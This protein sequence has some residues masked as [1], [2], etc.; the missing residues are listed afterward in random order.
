MPKKKLPHVATPPYDTDAFN[1]LAVLGLIAAFHAG[2]KKIFVRF[3]DAN[4]VRQSNPGKA[5]AK[6]GWRFF[7]Q[8]ENLVEV[9]VINL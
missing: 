7:L 1:A 2:E 5:L 9:P 3:D 6:Q 4:T 8:P